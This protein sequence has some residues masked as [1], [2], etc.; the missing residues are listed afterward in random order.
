MI[1]IMDDG[2]LEVNAIAFDGDAFDGKASANAAIAPTAVMKG[3]YSAFISNCQFYNFTESSMS[4]FRA[5]KT[6]YAD[7]LEFTNCLFRDMSG[8]AIY[9]AAEK[10]YA[11]KYSAEY[12]SVKNCAFYK[13]LGYAVDLYRGGSDE[14]TTGPKIVVDHCVLED[15]NNKERGAGM[16]LFG[17]QN[18]NVT[19]TLFSNT[20]RGGAAIR[21]DETHWDKIVVTNCNLYNSGKVSSFWGKVVTGPMFTAKPEYQSLS[22]YQFNLKSALLG[23]KATDGKNI[24]LISQL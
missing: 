22:N 15:V 2:I 23:T 4:P 21:F 8:D 17:V 16:R 5:Q 6:T 3:H 14:S 24:G 18:V 10:D 1:T 20:G 7:T 13:V 12:V 9:L 19:N 11:G